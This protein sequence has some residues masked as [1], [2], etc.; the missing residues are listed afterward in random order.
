[1]ADSVVKEIFFKRWV[2]TTNAILLAYSIATT[3]RDA[4]SPEIQQ[5]YQLNLLL[6]RWSWQTWVAIFAIGNFLVVLHGARLA[7]GKRDNER[8]TLAMELEEIKN[9]KPRIRLKD[10]DAI[11]C[12]SVDH[13]FRDQHGNTIFTQT[14]PFLKMRFINDPPVPSASA[15]AK[16]VRAKISF[17]RCDDEVCILSIDGRWAESTQPPALHPL[18][19]R[20]SLLGATFAIG[21]ERSVDIAYRDKRTKRHFA[22][23]NDNYN[24]D[25]FICPKHRLEGSRFRVEVRLRGILIDE[26]VSFI[27]TTTESGFSIER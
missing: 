9:T 11:Y 21:E 19:S 20:S 14:V 5:T 10:P 18:E 6:H 22:W 15:I 7:I 4:F 25:F 8:D 23:N 17:Y 2:V 27:F 26:K 16:D 13:N 12:E 3:F 24:Y 1:M